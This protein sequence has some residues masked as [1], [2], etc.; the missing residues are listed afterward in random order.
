MSSFDQDVDAMFDRA[1]TRLYDIARYYILEI[2]DILLRKTPGPDGA[3]FE[4]QWPLTTYDATGRLRDGWTWTRTPIGESSRGVGETAERGEYP[5]YG[6]GAVLRMQAALPAK[7]G[8][9]ST[10]ENQIGY[11]V[12]VLRGLRN[13]RKIGARDFIGPALKSQDAALQ[14]ATQRSAG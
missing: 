6:E 1:E 3:G 13:H 14:R 5:L 8:G 10:L 11:G 4:G 12:D 2:A 9:V 7:P